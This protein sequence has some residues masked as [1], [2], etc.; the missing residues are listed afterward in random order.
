MRQ[1]IRTIVSRVVG[2]AAAA[3]ATWMELAPDVGADFES[4]AVTLVALGVYGLVHKALD[5]AGLNPGDEA[6]PSDGS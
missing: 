1:F 4:A 5:A 3:A 2:A 6:R